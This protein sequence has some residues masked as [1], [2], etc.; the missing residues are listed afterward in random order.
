MESDLEDKHG[1]PSTAMEVYY[2]EFKGKQLGGLNW[3]G[4]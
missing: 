2:S 3:G 1:M 4:T